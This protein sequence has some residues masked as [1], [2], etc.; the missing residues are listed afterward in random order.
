MAA[1]LR[2]AGFLAP[3]RDA[4]LLVDAA[5]C[6]EELE[7]LV[8]R[9]IEGEPVAWLVGRTTFAGLEIQVHPG[10][11]VPRPQSVALVEHARSHAS[12]AAVDVC[13]GTGALGAAIGA[14]LATDAD[15]RAVANAR[16]NGLDARLGDLLEPVAEHVDLVVAVPPYVPADHLAHLP[17]DVRVH[18][19]ALALDGGA[20]GL[21]VVRRLVGQAAARDDV[22]TLL[23]EVG[24][25]EVEALAG[26]VRAHGFDVHARVADD[27]GDV[28]G[29]CATR[30][31]A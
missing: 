18:E 31:A 8:R 23:V 11:Y 26:I 2:S 29:V 15:P 27:D 16:A 21:E 24:I 5:L 17:R 20:D 25:D 13:C 19:P 14:A 6:D 7:A 22:R 9:R 10:V 28:R 12:A 30:S 3:D 1:R 4:E